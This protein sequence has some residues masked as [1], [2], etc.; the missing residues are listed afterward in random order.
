MKKIFTYL[1]LSLA[2]ISLSSC[3]NDKENT[4]ASDNKPKSSSTVTKESSS[5]KKTSPSNKQSQTSKPPQVQSPEQSDSSLVVN[6]NQPPVQPE[7]AT[8]ST[9]QTPQA[10]NP[11]YL[12][13]SEQEALDKLNST[14]TNGVY[15]HTSGGFDGTNYRFSFLSQGELYWAT[16]NA[17]TGDISIE[18][19]HPIHNQ[20]E[21]LDRI[22]SLRDNPISMDTFDRSD[23]FHYQFIFVE[24]GKTLRATVTAQTGQVWYDVP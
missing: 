22:N 24:D 13:N 21:A 8:P 20:Q 19:D 3:K 11:T 14:S 6:D 18:P 17:M 10:T 16:V 7:I 4:T 5:K 2:I 9:E 1:F 15:V 12:I 23:G